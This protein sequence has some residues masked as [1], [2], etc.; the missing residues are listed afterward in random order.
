MSCPEGRDFLR[1]H[2]ADG[3]FCAGVRFSYAWGYGGHLAVGAVL[4]A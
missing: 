3:A 4:C 1:M 2:R